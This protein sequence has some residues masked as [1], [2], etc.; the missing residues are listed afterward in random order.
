MMLVQ[1]LHT[2]LYKLKLPVPQLLLTTLFLKEIT[3]RLWVLPVQIL[4]FTSQ[5]AS[6]ETLSI[7]PSN[8]KVELFDLKQVLM[9]W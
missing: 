8:G 6:I 1:H 3:L 9:F 7:Q 4:K 5:T 2:I